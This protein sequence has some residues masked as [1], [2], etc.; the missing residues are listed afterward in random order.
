[1]ESLF[2]AA[3]ICVLLGV[4]C[5]YVC[6]LLFALLARIAHGEVSKDNG[7]WYAVIVISVLSFPVWAG[8]R[9]GWTDFSEY[10]SLAGKIFFFCIVCTLIKGILDQREGRRG[11][12]GCIARF[13]QITDDW[14]RVMEKAGRAVA[15]HDSAIWAAS[16]GLVF[17]T[18]LLSVCFQESRI[19]L[20]MLALII[21][22]GMYLG[23]SLHSCQ[24]LL[25][26]FFL[27]AFVLNA[28]A[29]VLS[30]E[31]EH[32][33]EMLVLAALWGEAILLWGAAI[34]AAD[35][36][37]A[38]LALLCTNTIMTLMALVGNALLPLAQG[39]DGQQAMAFL[40]G[41]VFP[42][43]AAGYA[44]R[45]GKSICVYLKNRKPERVCGPK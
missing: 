37:P 8:S 29:A 34:L 27:L 30:K 7:L 21:A 26:L 32:A 17:G 22:Y 44:A 28:Q 3:W 4:G 6:R 24:R 19:F 41:V 23:C 42:L 20:Y 35:E 13:L 36:A 38:Q 5:V 11:F 14:K 33:K 15:A 12:D 31:P 45:L 16:L 1:M 43:L 25:A 2:K 9:E 40:Y 18:V 10:V 39:L